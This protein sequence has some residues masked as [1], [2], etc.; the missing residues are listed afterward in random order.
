MRAVGGRDEIFHCQGD[1]HPQSHTFRHFL[2][3]EFRKP[4]NSGY[5]VF[6]KRIG[7]FK[8]VLYL[9]HA[10]PQPLPYQQPLRKANIVG[11]SR[12]YI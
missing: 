4:E 8:V 3:G 12:G 7:F 11:L 1:P 6:G 9:K 2:F 5:A 10:C